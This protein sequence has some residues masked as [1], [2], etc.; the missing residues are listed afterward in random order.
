MATEAHDTGG[1]ALALLRHLELLHHA[2]EDV[3]LLRADDAI[4]LVEDERG[5]A[6]D[7]DRLRPGDA[8]VDLL[9]VAPG[10]E[11]VAQV[12]DVEAVLA[13][14]LQ[15]GV[16]VAEVAEVLE[17]GAEEV[18]VQAVTVVAVL[19]CVLCGLEREMRVG[20]EGAPAR[21]LDSSLLAAQLEV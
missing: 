3:V 9:A 5:H 14:D 2:L 16:E 8:V 13:A 21:E 19:L 1:L 12:V 18:A 15:Q 4:A 20:R 6:G 11:R 10:L 7:A 17:V